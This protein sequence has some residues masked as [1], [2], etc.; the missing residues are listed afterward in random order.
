MMRKRSGGL[1]A[2]NQ[3]SYLKLAEIAQ[4][5][6]GREVITFNPAR[7]NSV[8]SPSKRTMETHN[9]GNSPF[10]TPRQLPGREVRNEIEFDE[11]EYTNPEKNKQANNSPS[12]MTMDALILSDIT[13]MDSMLE[14]KSKIE[15]HLKTMMIGSRNTGKHSLINASFHDSQK[16]DQVLE[17]SQNCFDLII[18]RKEDITSM[19]KYHFWIQELVDNRYD[20]YIKLYYPA[21]QCFI[22][23]YSVDDHKSFEDIEKSIAMLKTEIPHQKFR[24][25]LIANKND[26]L[27]REVTYEEGLELKQKHGLSWFVET[28]R[29]IEKD[30]PQIIRKIDELIGPVK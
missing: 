22:F 14:E 20:T 13:E 26:K 29:Y 1:H 23:V 5:R 2:E 28:N 9:L 18:K 10:P 12:A 11:F 27:N 21:V 24:G 4:T 7:R 25:I 3:E 15:Y 8:K 6:S 17:D 30:T 16:E 19:K